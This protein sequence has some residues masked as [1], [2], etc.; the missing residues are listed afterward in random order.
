MWKAK[1][2]AN[3]TSGERILLVGSGML[4]H[5]L[6][7]TREETSDTSVARAFEAAA[8]ETL[9]AST[10]Q[11]R[12]IRFLDLRG[13][14]DWLDAH[15]TAEHVLPLYMTLGAGLELDGI[16]VWSQGQC[17]IGQ[18]YYS[19]RLGQLPNDSGEVYEG[20]KGLKQI[21]RYPCS[22]CNTGTKF[23]IYL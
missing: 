17:I 7:A 9:N 22:Q 15:P 1:T 13:R 12:N 14:H 10:P 18:S 8:H 5:N 6:R 20:A 16:E 4:C 3:H 21:N 11:E 19:F 2:I 23:N